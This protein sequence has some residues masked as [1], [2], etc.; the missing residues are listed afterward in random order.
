MSKKPLRVV[1]DA[2]VLYPFSLRDT[3]LRA[4]E[5]GLYQILWSSEIL[6]ET[7]RNL[8][9]LLGP[10]VA[11]R[12]VTLMKDAFPE[13]EVEGY[14]PLVSKQKNH[15]KDRHVAAAAEKASAEWIV[16]QNLRDFRNLPSGICA[17]SPD[18]FLC[19]LFER[20]PETLVAVIREQSRA[21][22]NPPVSV[23][24]LLDGLQRTVPRFAKNARMR[25]R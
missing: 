5:A 13:A 3:L 23:E 24:Q 15:P 8:V 2:D 18:D 12:L 7:R 25:L 21:L 16:T 17:Q 9:T 4:A 6:E 20:D 11:D 10:S 14:E 1:L 19:S 22:R